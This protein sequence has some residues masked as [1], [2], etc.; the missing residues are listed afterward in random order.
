[1]KPRFFLIA[2]A[3]AGAAALAGCGDGQEAEEMRQRAEE[4]AAE[5]R[6]EAERAIGRA[7]ERLR[8]AV[9]EQRLE[10]DVPQRAVAVLHPTAGNDVTGTVTFAPGE[11]GLR[12]A[13]RAAGLGPGKHGYHIHIYGDCSAADGTSAGTH[14]NLE[15]S[16]LNP[17]EDIGYITGNLGNLE[18]GEDGEAEHETVLEN[19]ELTGPKSIIGRAVIVHAKANDPEEPP[20]GAAGA[21]QACGVIGIA[22]P[23]G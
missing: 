7:E 4:T 21:R 15:G 12:V 3:F 1:M 16:S 22:G 20:I 18:A 11:E 17:P 6:A 19:G 2:V 5:A 10:E 8:E 13:T 9:T 14:F 23:K